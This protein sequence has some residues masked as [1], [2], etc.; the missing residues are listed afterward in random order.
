M[1]LLWLIGWVLFVVGLVTCLLCGRT[2]YHPSAI[3]ER[4]CGSCHVFH[5][6]GV[7]LLSFLAARTRQLVAQFNGTTPQD[8]CPARRHS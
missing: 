2:S 3:A 4:Y 6:H 8:S 1:P 7:L 5:E